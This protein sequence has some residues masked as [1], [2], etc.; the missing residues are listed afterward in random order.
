MWPSSGVIST[1][2]SRITIWIQRVDT[3]VQCLHQRWSEL[4]GDCLTNDIKLCL[5]ETSPLVK[6]LHWC[7]KTLGGECSMT[8]V[9]HSFNYDHKASKTLL[10]ILVYIWP[11]SSELT[12]E[13]E[14][15]FSLPTFSATQTFPMTNV[16]DQ[17]AMMNNEQPND[18]T[19]TQPQDVSTLLMWSVLVRL[20]WLKYYFSPNPFPDS[21]SSFPCKITPYLKH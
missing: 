2:P 1:R 3:S 19:T 5:E 15:F 20:N 9:L 7:V 14:Q 13:S 18:D 21:S 16:V 10:Y 17:R 12:S 4:L 8:K 11:G 6:T